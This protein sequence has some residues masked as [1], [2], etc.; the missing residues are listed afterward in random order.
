[1]VL[2]GTVEKLQEV[3]ITVILCLC[4][5]VS[6][7]GTNLL[8]LGIFSLNLTFEDFLISLEKIQV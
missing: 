5:S 4:V 6:T 8:L 1:V 2:L 3:T 7:H